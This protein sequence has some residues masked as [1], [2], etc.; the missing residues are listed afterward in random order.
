MKLTKL[1]ST[2]LVSINVGKYQIE[3]ETSIKRSKP[4][5][6]VEEFVFPFWK[7]NRVA[8]EFPIPGS[9]LRIDLVNFDKK[10]AIEV[11]PRQHFQFN[12]FLHG[13]KS[14]FLAA[15]KRDRD[16]RQWIEKN[17]FEFVEL[18]E[19]HLKNLSVE[20]IEEEFGVIL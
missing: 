12:A 16:K 5:I 3:W 13:S 10:I 19:K 8:R 11:S 20:L 6:Q 17:E 9:K 4:Q 2:K 18:E 1:S 7:C 14:S 15:L